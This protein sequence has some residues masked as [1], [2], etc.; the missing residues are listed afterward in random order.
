MFA[1]R[2]CLTKMLPSLRVTG[3]GRGGHASDQLFN[4]SGKKSSEVSKSPEVSKTSNCNSEESKA[5]ELVLFFNQS[6]PPVVI[7]TSHPQI[8]KVAESVEP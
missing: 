4:F 7:K 1:A 5:S 8:E 6:L 2:R 3:I